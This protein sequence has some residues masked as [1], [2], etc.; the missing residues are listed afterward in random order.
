MK[1]WA[2][3]DL[4]CSNNADWVEHLK[5]GSDDATWN[6][7]GAT[8]LMHVRNEDFS[9]DP[10]MVIVSPQLTVVDAAMRT[11]TLTVSAATMASTPPGDWIYDILVTAAGAVTVG[12][13]GNAQILMGVTRA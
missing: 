3:Q 6:L 2:T 5:L 11:V 13:R 4:I 9:S 7:T 8:L 12:M 10:I 1:A